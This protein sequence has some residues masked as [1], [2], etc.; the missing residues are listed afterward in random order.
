MRIAFPAAV[1]VLLA[2]LLSSCGEHRPRE[3]VAA[4]V[5]GSELSLTDLRA[6][7]ARAPAAAPDRVLEALIE[8][9]LFAQKALANRLDARPQVAQALRAARR[10]ILAQAYLQ[11][12]IASAS[13]DDRQAVRTYY[14]QHPQLFAERR[15]Y[16]ILE[17]S[18]SAQAAD[19]DRLEEKL[20]ATRHL[21]DVADWLRARNVRFQADASTRLPEQIPAD[22]LARIASMRDGDL[23]LLRSGERAS[24]VQLAQSESAP[25]SEAQAQPA[26][27]R[28][29]LAAN[30]L[31]SVAA[32][33]KNLRAAAK[34][35]YVLDLGGSPP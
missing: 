22:F 13:D 10:Q 35:E 23:L 29:L 15:S 17:L 16:R 14:E 25:M 7:T 11:Q 24:V 26:I 32:T 27:E 2:S 19:F 9:E 33:L 20:R 31:E 34:I 12:V 5:N 21:G 18:F 3:I 28:H 8:E 30:R 4:K 6:A 1:A